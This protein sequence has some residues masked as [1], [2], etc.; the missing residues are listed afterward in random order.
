[1]RS[2]RLVLN[3]LEEAE[4]ISSAPS[5]NPEDPVYPALTPELRTLK[6]RLLPLQQVE[7]ALVGKLNGS[8]NSQS[9]TLSP[10]T[11]LPESTRGSVSQ[12]VSINSAMPWKG[13]FSR[14]ISNARTSVDGPEVNEPQDS[15]NA[16][17]LLHACTDDMI[18]LWN[19]RTVRA[20]LRVHRLRLE[21]MAGLCVDFLFQASPLIGLKLP[22]L[23]I[24]RH[25]AFVRAYGWF[26]HLAT[27]H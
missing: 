21:D 18:K 23:D 27:A 25:I 11:N 19:D 12:E 15:R 7:E 3:A 5:P 9:A 20:I 22:G 4:A 6:M 8:G 13:A 26:V 10:L 17:Q 16:R 14:L 1:V 24:T 2:I